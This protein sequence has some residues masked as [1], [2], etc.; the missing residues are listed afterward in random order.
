MIPGFESELANSKD[1]GIAYACFIGKTNIN[2]DQL[3]W[4][5]GSEDIRVAPIIMGA[6]QGGIFQVIVGLVLI[7]VGIFTGGSTTMLG[8]AMLAGGVAQMLVP[9][10]QQAATKDKPD[11]G[12]SYNFNGPVNTSAQNNPVPEAYGQSIWG[13]AAISVSVYAEDAA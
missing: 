4:P 3:D 1:N 7:V 6:K 12:A 13:G 9:T 11:N 5:V 2:E 10:A 8:V